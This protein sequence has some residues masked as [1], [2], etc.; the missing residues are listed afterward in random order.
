MKQVGLAL[1]L[2]ASVCSA[3]GSG[4]LKPAATNL[5]LEEDLS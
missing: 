2:V 3:R 5:T 4:D 1:L